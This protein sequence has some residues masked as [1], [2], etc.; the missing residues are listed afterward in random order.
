M[1]QQICW[2]GCQ[3]YKDVK[4]SNITEN[5]TLRYTYSTHFS[6]EWMHILC[7]VV[8]FS[9]TSSTSIW[10][11]LYLPLTNHS[12]T[13]TVIKHLIR[14]DSISVAKWQVPKMLIVHQIQNRAIHILVPLCHLSMY[15]NRCVQFNLLYLYSGNTFQTMAILCA[16]KEVF[17]LKPVYLS[18]LQLGV[19]KTPSKN[20]LVQR[21]LCTFE[22]VDLKTYTRYFIWLSIQV[23][24]INSL[25]FSVYWTD[26]PCKMRNFIKSNIITC[27]V[28]QQ[29]NWCWLCEDSEKC[30]TNESI[31]KVYNLVHFASTRINEQVICTRLK[32]NFFNRIADIFQQYQS[33]LS[34]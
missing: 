15:Y 14:T 2:K 9:V 29:K 16:G 26:I 30:A 27:Y 4:K 23:K 17:F 3:Q 33:N 28:I 25:S 22:A 21:K 8:V 12:M 20:D 11:W 1:Y 18:S 10:M 34:A 7:D 31:E 13:C 5:N 6:W 32:C 24:S 19:H